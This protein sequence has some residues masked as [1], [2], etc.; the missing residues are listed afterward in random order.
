[1]SKIFKVKNILRKSFPELV[2][3]FFDK[4]ARLCK[5]NFSNTSG[6]RLLKIFLT[7]WRGKQELRSGGFARDFEGSGIGAT[8]LRAKKIFF[9]SSS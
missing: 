1:M 8:S 4:R 5:K 2:S 7:R 9:F 3:K 6:E